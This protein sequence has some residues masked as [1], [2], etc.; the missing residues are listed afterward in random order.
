MLV[1]LFFDLALSI[2][3]YIDVDIQFCVRNDLPYLLTQPVLVEM[4]EVHVSA[5]NVPL[6]CRRNRPTLQYYCLLTSQ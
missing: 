5:H 3:P 2:R 6:H 4:A 1:I